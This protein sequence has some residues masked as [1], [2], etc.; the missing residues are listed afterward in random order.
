MVYVKH[1]DS[2]TKIKKEINDQSFDIKFTPGEIYWCNVGVNVASE[3]DGKGE[4][5][6]R[7]VI[8]LGV[9]KQN[10]LFVLPLTSGHKEGNW[11]FHLKVN[12]K[13]SSICLHQAKTVSKNRLGERIEKL[14]VENLKV[15]K[16]AFAKFY[17]L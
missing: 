5:F 15:I 2:W 12:N 6:S 9:F 1:F 8:I 16:G 11:H 14:S 7:P 10:L 3:I 13:D 17:S 4:S